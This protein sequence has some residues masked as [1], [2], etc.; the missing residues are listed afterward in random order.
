MRTFPQIL[1]HRSNHSVVS[2]MSSP[3]VITSRDGEPS[4]NNNSPSLFCRL[5]NELLCMIATNFTR[6]ADVSALARTCKLL[7]GNATPILYKSVVI[8]DEEKL[9]QLAAGRVLYGPHLL[10]RIQKFDLSMDWNG[11][12]ILP[13]Y[14]INHI[15][16][17]TNLQHLAI[18][19]DCLKNGR[20]LTRW[21]MLMPKTL[22]SQ[23]VSSGGK[24]ICCNFPSS[25]ALKTINLIDCD[26]TGVTLHQIMRYPRAH[27]SISAHSD[28][29]VNELRPV[30]ARNHYYC[31]RSISRG[32]IAN[33][34]ESFRYDMKHVHE[35]I[36]PAPGMDLLKS[37]SKFAANRTDIVDEILENKHS[38]APSLRRIILV[39]QYRDAAMADGLRKAANAE[40][41]KRHW[42]EH[43]AKVECL[44]FP[45]SG[46]K[47]QYE[48][49][50]A[51]CEA[52]G[53]DPM[54]LYEDS[55]RREVLRE[56][57][58]PAVWEIPEQIA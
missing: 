49:L 9:R 37:I 40:T 50:A 32:E 34:L 19:Y 46:P 21:P 18:E 47:K 12:T 42:N 52:K 13:L 43:T 39:L 41:D 28:R 29:D 57:A 5:S 3:G 8:N 4:K 36:V 54:P 16:D 7:H 56:G 27:K 26:I 20:K 48:K 51:R 22:P 31:L 58:G 45:V 23:L 53:V 25:T 6:P 35:A 44:R 24:D 55:V 2:P 10:E 33:S 14:T 17:M 1:H 15:R 38:I 30:I 11:S